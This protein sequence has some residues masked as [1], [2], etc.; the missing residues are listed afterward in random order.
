VQK[1]R[2]SQQEPVQALQEENKEEGLKEGPEEGPK[3]AVAA[4]GVV[5]TEI[6]VSSEPQNKGSSSAIESSQRVRLPYI[7]SSQE[8][9]QGSLGSI[10][11]DSQEMSEEDDRISTISD[12]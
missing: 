1:Q 3:E 8:Q 9:R 10:L 4:E 6:V 12:Q 11:S 5:S 7:Q 2:F